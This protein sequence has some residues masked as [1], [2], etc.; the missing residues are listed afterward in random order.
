MAKT[1]GRDKAVIEW[2][3]EDDQPAIRYLTLTQVLDKRED[4]PEVEETREAIPKRGWA[5]D[6][7]AQQDPAGWWVRPIHLYTPKYLSTNWMLLVLADLGLTKSDA[8]VRRAADAWKKLYAKED[9]GFGIDASKGSHLCTTGNT[10]R[11]LVQFG[12]ADDPAVVRSFGWMEKNRSHLGGWSC[13]LSGRNLDSW[14]PMS[15]FAAYPKPKWTAG[16]QRAVEEGAEFYLQRE[17]HEQGDHYEPWYRF[18][19][20]VHYYYDLLVGL[21][22]MTALGYGEDPRMQHAFDALRK[23]RRKDGRWNLD[24]VHPDVEGGTA[25]WFEKHPKDRPTPFALEKVGAPSKMITFRA[26]RVLRRMETGD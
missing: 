24:A 15:A 3:L 14:E 7:L 13:F 2:L 22:F 11:A 1:T 23:K 12:Y 8:R 5:A 6:I 9:G 16:M 19:F 4:D 26:M 18:H 25:A 10:A 20:P 21:E 17:L